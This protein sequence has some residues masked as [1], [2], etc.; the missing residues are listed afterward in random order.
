MTVDDLLALPDDGW[1]YELVEGVLVRMAGSGEL[2]TT[3]A[4]TIISV[5]NTFVRARRLGRVTSSDGV[6][7]FPGAE[8]GLLPDVGFYSSRYFPL[9]V[10]R[11][12]PIP[13]APELAVEVA[14]PSQN[15]DD[16]AAKARLYLANGTR[17]V[18]VVWPHAQRIDVWRAGDVRMPAVQLGIQDMLDG[19]DVVPGFT[20]PVADIFA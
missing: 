12:K 3:I 18:W 15:E 5:L 4:A 2:A 14:S 1:Q 11:D 9:I 7:R 19:E 8:T 13:F 16:L 17:L 6:Y 10:D 20:H